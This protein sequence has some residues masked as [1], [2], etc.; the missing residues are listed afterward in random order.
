[1][2][3]KPILFNSEMSTAVRSGKKTQT[4]RV[5]KKDCRYGDQYLSD[6]EYASSIGAPMSDYDIESPYGKKGDE[7][8]IKE[9]WWAPDSYSLMKPS[10]IPSDQKIWYHDTEGNFDAKTTEFKG[11][12]YP[13]IFMCRWMSR[14]QALI[15]DIRVEAADEITTEDIIAEGLSTKLREHDAE[16]DLRRKWLTLWDSINKERGYG[17]HLSP[18]VWV[19]EFEVMK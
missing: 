5:M 3:E 1:M 6:V 15:K 19:V 8:W 7:L 16:V 10:D 18:P 2:K 17:I 11:R 13:S 12:K 14:T 4:R 9:S